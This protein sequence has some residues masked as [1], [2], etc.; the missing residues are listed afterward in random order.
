MAFTPT[1]SFSLFTVSG[2]LGSLAV[3]LA[4]LSGCA[5]STTMVRLESIPTVGGNL[6]QEEKTAISRAVS[7][8]KA[9][10]KWI[11]HFEVESPDRVG[12]QT[13]RDYVKLRRTMFGWRVES[14]HRSW[15]NIRPRPDFHPEAV[16]EP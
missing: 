8:S 13:Y 6:S 9:R 14:V 3:T 1:T 12:V 10:D 15:P 2:S 11:L 4:V 7:R 5:R 16:A